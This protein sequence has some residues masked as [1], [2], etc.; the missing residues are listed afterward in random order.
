M[1]NIRDKFQ[2]IE[3]SQRIK[4]LLGVDK[5]N[6]LNFRPSH[7]TPYIVFR[8]RQ[9]YNHY[10]KILNKPVVDNQYQSI[11]VNLFLIGYL[12]MLKPFKIK[13]EKSSNFHNIRFEILDIDGD[14]INF[15][16]P[17]HVRLKLT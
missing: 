4:Y 7:G 8:Y 13:S 2:I 6:N 11:T 3:C 9:N 16:S 14:V 10:N 5:N 17:F 12:F 1:V 15:L